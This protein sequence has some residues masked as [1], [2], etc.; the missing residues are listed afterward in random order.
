MLYP[1]ATLE[2]SRQ[3]KGPL[4]AVMFAVLR[5]MREGGATED[6][7]GSTEALAKRT[8]AALSEHDCDVLVDVVQARLD[9]ARQLGSWVESEKLAAR[10]TMV[11]AH[12]VHDALA[13]QGIETQIRH[14]HLAAGDFPNP[15]TDVELWVRGIDLERA[16]ELL[17]AIDTQSAET[18]ACPACG[19][20]NPAHFGQCW[21]C[22]GA[23]DAAPAAPSGEATDE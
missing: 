23:L 5:G 9:E 16:S 14:E 19:A 21:S 1:D 13:Q 20:E 8:F 12:I 6:E 10:L 3:M 18:T 22:N 7:L 2:E 11:E 15:G 4:G 17:Q